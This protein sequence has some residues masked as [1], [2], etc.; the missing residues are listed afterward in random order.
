MK[1]P[2]VCPGCHKHCKFGEARCKYGC[3]YFAKLGE[4]KTDPCPTKGCKHKW[5]A[6]VAQGGVAWRLFS[7]CRRAKKALRNKKVAENQLFAPLTDGE[8]QLLC[9]LLDR[10]NAGLDEK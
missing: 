9:D 10:L 5:E 3:R 6:Y 7:F 1:S 4:Q 2:M 8:Q